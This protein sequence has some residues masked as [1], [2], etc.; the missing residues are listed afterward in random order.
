[1]EENSINNVLNKKP[2]TPADVVPVEGGISYD[3]PSIGRVIIER[4]QM[5]ALI[6]CVLLLIAIIYFK[7]KKKKVNKILKICFVISIIIFMVI[8][9]IIFSYYFFN[10]I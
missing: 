4:A 8:S 5:S 2:I 1:M 9:L 7:I 3:G 6:I 10:N